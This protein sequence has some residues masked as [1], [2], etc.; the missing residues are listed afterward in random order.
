VSYLLFGITATGH[1]TRAEWGLGGSNGTTIGR[2]EGLWQD[3]AASAFDETEAAAATAAAKRGRAGF[4]DL[5]EIAA[6][7]FADSTLAEALENGGRVLTATPTGRSV[8]DVGDT[9][10]DGLGSGYANGTLRLG[11]AGANWNWIKNLELLLTSLDLES[12]RFQAIE[13]FNLVD[14][15]LKLG[16]FHLAGAP[17]GEPIRVE[18]TNA[19]RGEFDFAD[20]PTAVQ[21]D[22]AIWS[23]S[24]TGQNSHAVTGTAYNDI[25][26]IRPGALTLASE[27]AR[28]GPGT[29]EGNERVF[30]GWGSGIAADLGGGDD[31][32]DATAQR[33]YGTWPN[34]RIHLTYTLDRVDGGSGNDVIRTGNGGDVIRGGPDRGMITWETETGDQPPLLVGI[35]VGDQLSGGGPYDRDTFH[36]GKGDGVDLIT[37][38]QPYYDQLVLHALDGAPTQTVVDHQGVPSLLVTDAVGDEEG[39]LLLGVSAPLP[40][41]FIF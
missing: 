39:V 31:L 24:A 29:V 3:V 30:N 2:L 20:A 25:V 26:T 37:D 40:D 22:I 38:F 9:D 4:F 27:L 7:G 19:K 11:L 8:L 5:T 6:D 10:G 14:V 13:I 41:I 34:L 23:N 16:D 32:F 1:G 36:W 17:R 28:H 15:R 33:L 12:G 18:V 35:S 21:L